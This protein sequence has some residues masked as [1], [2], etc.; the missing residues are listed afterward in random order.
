MRARVVCALALA[1]V[2]CAGL[3][4]AQQM[5]PLTFVSDYT[6]RPG[7]EEDFLQLVKTIGAPVRDKLMAEGVVLAWGVDVPLMRAPGQPTH[8]VWYDVAD[9]DGVQKVQTAIQAQIAKLAEEDKKAADEARK[10]G[11]KTAKSTAERIEET[12]DTGKTKDWVFRGLSGNY[13]STP[14]P[15]DLQPFTR[16]FLLTIKPGKYFEW[17]AAWDKYNKPLLDKLVADG[18]VGAYGIGTEEVRTSGDFTHYVATSVARLA[19]FEKTRQAFI[20]DRA[21]RSAEEND[22]ITETFNNLTDPN[23]ARS[24]IL[25]SIIFKVAPPKK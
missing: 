4:H 7:K 3:A 15:A 9:W 23:A 16:I 18:V 20:A 11:G 12:L 2:W 21:K 22:R 8:S 19:D 24:F 17:K 25:H 10:K 5:Q 6:V 1:L 13:S 14:P